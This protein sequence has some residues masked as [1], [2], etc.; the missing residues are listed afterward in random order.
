MS[1]PQSPG[2]E[3]PE[4]TQRPPSDAGVLPKRP[5]PKWDDCDSLTAQ[6]PVSVLPGAPRRRL[7]EPQFTGTLIRMEGPS[8][9]Q[10]IAVPARMTIGRGKDVGCHFSEEGVSR[11]HAEVVR[12]G[13]EYRLRDLGSKNGTF[14]GDGAV[15]SHTLRHGDLIRIGPGVTLRFCLMDSHQRSLI[16]ELYETSVRDP[17]TGA[18]NRRHF[19]ERLEAELAYARRHRSEL[20]LLI[21]DIDYFKKVNDQYGHLEGDRVL[22]E[23]SL[24]AARHLRA[25]DLFSRY[26]GEE[27]VVLL[28]G[29]PVIGAQRAAERLRVAIAKGVHFGA[30]PCPVSVSIGCASLA[31]VPDGGSLLALADERLYEAKQ[32]GRGR[33]VAYG[34]ASHP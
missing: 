12:L 1:G 19:G 31:C 10:V 3:G 27:F 25:E 30:P 20:S 11:V 18:F 21:L 24:V 34:R 15:R 26:G 5:P 16:A 14:V 32:S 7:E 33:V 4:V 2:R 13:D 9:G 17:L 8:A 28:R 29:Q 23:L 6:I 22:R